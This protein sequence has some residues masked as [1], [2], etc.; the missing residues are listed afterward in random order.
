MIGVR[1]LSPTK[2]SDGNLNAAS[3]HVSNGAREV[4]CRMRQTKEDILWKMTLARDRRA[5]GV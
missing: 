1:L 5:R 4:K 2:G 3:S